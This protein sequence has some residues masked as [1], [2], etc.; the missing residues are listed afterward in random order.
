MKSTTLGI[1]DR[2][3]CKTTG[4]KI[5]QLVYGEHGDYQM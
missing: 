3:M 5:L 1:V 2:K 4:Q